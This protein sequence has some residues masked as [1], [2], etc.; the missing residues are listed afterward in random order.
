VFG[1]YVLAAAAS[2][3]RDTINGSANVTISGAVANGGGG[4][5]NFTYSGTGVLTLQGANTYSGTTTVSSGSVFLNGSHTGTGGVT[6]AYTIGTSTVAAKLAGN[7]STAGAV[8]VN[9]KRHD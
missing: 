4:I 2:R 7:G 8:T 5:D 3:G 1:G 6:G 9:F